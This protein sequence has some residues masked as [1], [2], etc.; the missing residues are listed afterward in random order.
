M[1]KLAIAGAILLTTATTAFAETTDAVVTDHYR[2]IE[3]TIPHDE[4]VCNTVDVPIY[5]NSQMNTEG[6]IL[7]GIIGGVIGNNIGKGSGKDAATGVGALTGAIIGGQNGKRDIIGY[8]QETRCHIQTT[9]STKT[10]SVYDYSTVT[11]IE[12]G[13][14]YVVRFNKK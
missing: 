1:K 6:A 12:D 8:K 2:T 14:K 7:G 3:R 13:R 11:F 4:K 10:E 5:G 9:Y